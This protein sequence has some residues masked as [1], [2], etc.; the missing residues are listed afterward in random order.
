MKNHFQ[1]ESDFF[2]S[3]PQSFLPYWNTERRRVG[4]VDERK[5]GNL[6][7]KIYAGFRRKKEA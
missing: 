2:C 6:K 4:Y 1:S 7:I 5:L 3:F